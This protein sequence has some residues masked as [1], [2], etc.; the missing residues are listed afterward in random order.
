MHFVKII[1]KRIKV[2]F[3]LIKSFHTRD[4]FVPYKGI[5]KTD[6]LI[7]DDIFP[8]PVSGFRYEEFKI[9]LN[10]FERSKIVVD[11]TA[12]SIVN[13]PIENHIQDVGEFQ[14]QHEFKNKIKYRNGFVNINAKLFYCIFLNNISR[15][16]LWLEKYKIPFI[17]TLYPGGGFKINETISD[18]KLVKAFAS[19]MFRKV[20]VT[21]KITC[22]Y[23]IEKNLCSSE[24]IEFVFGGV[25]PQISLNKNLI[26]KKSYLINKITFDICF[27]AAKYTAKGEDKGYDVFIEFAK[28]IAPIYDFIHFHVIGGFSEFDID[29]SEIKE[30]V[31]FYGYQNFNA[32]GDIYQ[33]MD[34]LISPNKA[35]IL[36]KG[37]FDGFP[38]GT[39][40]EA[41]LNGV[42]VLITDELKQNNTFRDNVHL[43]LIESNQDSIMQHVIDLIE[44]PEKLYSIS[45]N[46]KEKFIEVYSNKIQMEP[47]ITL[48]Q[49][50]IAQLK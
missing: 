28:S 6:L 22:D 31:K 12:Y 49:N 41:A 16:L 48:L 47:R 27:C 35:F 37:A 45:Q 23:L 14:S 10:I 3:R 50:E 36:G 43:I 13:K 11:N 17:F 9:L 20:I 38:L 8:N 40:V 15:N 5:N 2:F 32:L 1:K 21:Q 46:G 29:V 25:V 4:F 18:E 24:K 30:K 19:P 7:F 39:V 33:N 26:Q 44:N 34:V 42:C